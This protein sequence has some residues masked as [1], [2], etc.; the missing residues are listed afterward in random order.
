MD[1]KKKIIKIVS[2][3]FA[4]AAVSLV[5]FTMSQ[6]DYEMVANIPMEQRMSDTEFYSKIGISFALLAASFGG[7]IYVNKDS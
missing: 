2:T 1:Y 4:L 5:Y 3:V 7:A 6:T